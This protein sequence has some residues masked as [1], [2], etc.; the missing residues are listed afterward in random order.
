M[1][2]V[3]LDFSFPFFYKQFFLYSKR[4]WFYFS[5]F[6]VLSF[7]T[8]HTH[9]TVLTKS[10]KFYMITVS[11][12]ENK[13]KYFQFSILF[14]ICWMK[15]P[16][17]KCHFE[18]IHCIMFHYIKSKIVCIKQNGNQPQGKWQ[19]KGFQR[20][21]WKQKHFHPNQVCYISIYKVFKLLHRCYTDVTLCTLSTRWQTSKSINS[22][23]YYHA[24]MLCLYFSVRNRNLL[25][26][27][28]QTPTLF[29]TECLFM[30]SIQVLTI[31]KRI[32]NIS[33]EL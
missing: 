25:L 12:R 7:M 3:S 1:S 8:P 11:K 20:I 6:F 17:C 13:S 28:L 16:A 4:G 19:E 23:F 2:I 10:N 24:L 26:P 27:W 9:L 21:L 5:H 31:S 30:S 32:I 29:S 18:M 14:T 22:V 33:T 15:I